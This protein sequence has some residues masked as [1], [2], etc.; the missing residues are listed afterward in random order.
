VTSTERS[1]K[2][3]STGKKL[4]FRLLLPLVTLVLGLVV[5]EAGLHWLAEH[6][7]G[8]G[9]LFQPDGVTSWRYLPGLDLVRKN[10]DGA[11][12]RI[13][14]DELGFRETGTWHP[15]VRR[16]LL[17]L[18]DSLAFG[19]GIDIDDRFDTLVA[20]AHPDLSVI[21]T[22][23]MGYDTFQEIL[24]ARP[25]FA[26]LG[27][28]DTLLLLT[29]S[30][31]FTDLTRAA[32]A[33][34]PTPRFSLAADGSAVEGFPGIT[35]VGW[36]RDR[37]YIASRVFAYFIDD[38]TYSAE[39]EREG[40][41]LFEAMVRLNLVPLTERSVR[42]LLA[43]YDY[44]NHEAHNA[45]LIR[46]AYDRLCSLDGIGCLVVN[47]VVERDKRMSPH[48]QRDGHWNRAGNAAF[49]GQLLPLF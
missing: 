9:K 46:A 33:G 34:R 39:T 18:G 16:R 19:E 17:I 29:C 24:R 15:G 20:R 28:G 30:N 7:Y 32:L 2:P 13:V 38:P 36:L 25:Y 41:V 4:V 45:A 23:V 3:I 40:L 42:V 14:T 35:L 48:I 10:A 12:W 31:D 44:S 21:N 22:G 6:L 27:Q 49:A 11:P 1:A 47:E 5:V 37:S 43:Y 26:D 8:M